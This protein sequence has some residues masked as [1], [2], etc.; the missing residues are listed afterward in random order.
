MR[1]R[2][3]SRRETSPDSVAGLIQGPGKFSVDYRSLKRIVDI[4]GSADPIVEVFLPPEAD[5]EWRNLVFR[6]M[7]YFST[8]SGRS[9]NAVAAEAILAMEDVTISNNHSQHHPFALTLDKP[10]LSINAYSS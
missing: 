10:N 5:Q 3:D 4:A 9:N 7:I 2:S 6:S 1:L 8:K